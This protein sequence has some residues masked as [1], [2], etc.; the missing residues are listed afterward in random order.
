MGKM[1]EEL[2]TIGILA[3][4]IFGGL[5][6]Y[7]YVTD[8]K[9]AWRDKSSHVNQM[10]SFVVV[11]CSDNLGD[12]DGKT[13][14]RIAY[15]IYQ[16]KKLQDVKEQKVVECARSVMSKYSPSDLGFL[17][18]LDANDKEVITYREFYKSISK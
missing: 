10:Y 14:S 8:I 2:K 4:I 15:G 11:S 5:Y 12:R 17:L 9:G 6:V 3:V 1:I 18:T 16:N 13:Y 7:Y